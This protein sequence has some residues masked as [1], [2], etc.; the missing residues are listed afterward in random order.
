MAKAGSAER[1]IVDVKANEVCETKE[2]KKW[3]NERFPVK[4]CNIDTFRDSVENY[5][6]KKEDIIE[7]VI[8]C[9]VNKVRGNVR[10]ESVVNKQRT[11][12]LFSLNPNL[13]IRD[14]V[15]HLLSKGHTTW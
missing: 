1:A 15:S 9:E 2:K 3:T 6:S 11:C 13:Q 12:S 10:L 14:E 8:S 4:S 5:F 7:R